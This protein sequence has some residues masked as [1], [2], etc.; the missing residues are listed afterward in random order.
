MNKELKEM[1]E[2]AKQLINIIPR[3]SKFKL[4]RRGIFG[5]YKD[6]EYKIRPFSYKDKIDLINEYGEKRYIEILSSVDTRD[7]EIMHFK[8]AYMLLESDDFKSFDEFL[9]SIAGFSAEVAVLYAAI[10][11]RGLATRPLFSEKELKEVIEDVKKK[12]KE[13]LKE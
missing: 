2:Q 1:T 4:K 6:R 13:K 5:G 8:I 10:E 7:Y 3:G 9:K 12:T 11:A